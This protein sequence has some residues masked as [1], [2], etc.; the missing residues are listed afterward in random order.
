MNRKKVDVIWL[1][2]SIISYFLMSVMFLLMPLDNMVPSLRDSK[3]TIVVGIGFWG[4]MIIG[5]AAQII[6]AM[7]WKAW[8]R[9]QRISERRSTARKLGAISFGANVIAV[10]ADIGVIISLCGLIVS[11]IFTDAAG[12]MCYVFLAAFSFTFCMHCIFNGKI[13]YHITHNYDG[14]VKY[15]RTIKINEHQKIEGEQ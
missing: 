15:A 9:L 5:I 11:V 7:R 8:C 13:Y 10:I 3:T 2:I 6:L 4:F 14:N 1:C 12:Y